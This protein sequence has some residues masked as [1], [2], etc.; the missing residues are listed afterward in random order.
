MTNPL[1]II[2]S[3]LIY[4][5]CLPLAVYVGYVLAQPFDRGSLIFLI[6]ATALPLVPFLLRWHHILLI[7]SWNLSLVL[8]FLPGAPYLWMIM[9]GLSLGLTT[10]QYVLKRN[11]QFVYVPS[12]AWALIFLA[13]VVLITAQLTGGF[14]MRSFGSSDSIGGKR[15]IYLLG[16]IIGY[17][18]LTS[19]RI[20]PHRTNLYVFLFFVGGVTALIGSFAPWIPGGLRIIFAFFPVESLASRAEA[21]A[22]EM[23]RFG[24]LALAG[25]SMLYLIFARHGM[26]GLFNLSE[27]WRFLPFNFKDGPSLNQ[28]WRILVL[29]AVF[30]AVMMG[31]FRSHIITLALLFTGLFYLERL[32]RTRLLPMLLL[33]G[34]LTAT[35]CLPFVD[36]MPL[37]VQR[38]L[39]FL[40]LNNISPLARMNADA[41]TEWRLKIWRE[42]IPTIPQ[43]LLIGKGY[44]IDAKEQAAVQQTQQFRGEGDE[45]AK[46]A[47]D[48]HSG[49]LS[50]IIP[51]GI[52]GVIGFVWFLVAG[53]RVL[54]NNY[55]YGE[56][57]N[58]HINTFLLAY[59]CT[60]VIM[61]FFIFG[62]VYSDLVMF[63]G[64]VGLGLAVN[65]VVRRP[66]P[67]ATT[68]N[69]AYLPFRLP[70]A[71]KI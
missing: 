24:G 26:A 33:T 39:S 6:V 20:P 4:G 35:V 1:N 28:P 10:L 36:K 54:L 52:F 47:G 7:L 37:S 58:R 51:L 56:A 50:V 19:Y 62:S 42:V 21:E 40:P 48:Y 69:P 8:F 71:A 57:A 22:Q 29:P 2:R 16:A 70:K 27:R 46:I 14:G 18:A 31:G 65:G 17:F 45:G 64:I 49:P 55:R 32:F 23:N 66:V 59:F 68:P 41:S 15:Y 43:Y 53:F 44:S 13:G 67:V 63:V 30:L 60:R 61:F 11:V 38:S 25:M 12:V 9:S 5:L 34:V 3:L